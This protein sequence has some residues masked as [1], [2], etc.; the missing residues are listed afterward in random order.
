M[1]EDSDLEVVVI[2]IENSID[3]HPFAPAEIPA[4]V[5]EYLEA[6]RASG[7]SEVR[8]IHGR[9]KGFQRA[10]IHSLLRRLPFVIGA[11]EAPA[12]CGGWGATVVLLRLPDDREV[13]TAD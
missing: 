13:D 7:F 5:E 2:P 6:A 8:L 3:L 12:E 9:G 11:R 1:S 4:L 10:R